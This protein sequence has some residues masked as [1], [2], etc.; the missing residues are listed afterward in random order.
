VH[1]AGGRP[2]TDFNALLCESDPF[3]K[4]RSDLGDLNETPRIGVK[5][6]HDVVLGFGDDLAPTHSHIKI[7][8]HFFYFLS[9]LFLIII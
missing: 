6:H 9:F 1:I 8:F 4:N 2:D 5:P 7:L 3:K